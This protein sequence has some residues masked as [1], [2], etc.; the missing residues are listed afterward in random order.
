[1]NDVIYLING[2][3][4]KFVRVYSDGGVLRG[5]SPRAKKWAW[6]YPNT[7]HFDGEKMVSA[8]RF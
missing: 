3:Q 8:K 6:L 2:R 1:M 5:Y 4:Y 7:I